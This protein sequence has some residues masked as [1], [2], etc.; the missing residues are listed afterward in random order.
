MPMGS[1]LS[2]FHFQSL[3]HFCFSR[4]LL[5]LNHEKKCV[6]QGVEVSSTFLLKITWNFFNL[7]ILIA[8]N[9]LNEAF[10]KIS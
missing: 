10:P 1:F 7:N 4:T 9:V 6:C 3:P 2:I 5:K 8:V